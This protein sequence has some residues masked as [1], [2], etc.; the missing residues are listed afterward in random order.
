MANSFRYIEHPSLQRPQPYRKLA[1][2]HRN[3]TAAPKLLDP[4]HRHRP[5]LRVN[6]C[7]H[8]PIA[9]RA[10]RARKAWPIDSPYR[11]RRPVMAAANLISWRSNSSTR[12]VN[13][14]WSNGSRV[15]SKMLKSP[16]SMSFSMAKYNYRFLMN[17]NPTFGNQKT[18]CRIS[19]RPYCRSITQ[20]VPNWTK[21]RNRVRSRY[22]RGRTASRTSS[23]LPSAVIPILKTEMNKVWSHWIS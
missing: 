13:K 23:I 19:F 11:T 21:S 8:R 4:S 5:L 16:T 22:C 14:V 18:F 15:R 2:L 1:Q 12:A 7:L 3:S 17:W 20:K 10:R 6:L 9:C